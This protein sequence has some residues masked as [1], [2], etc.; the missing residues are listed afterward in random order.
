MNKT[1]NATEI[2]LKSILQEPATWEDEL[3]TYAKNHRVPIIEP[4]SMNFIASLIKLVQPTHILEIGTAIGYSALSMHHA[5]PSAKITTLERDEEMVVNATE[6]IANYSLNNQIDI[7]KGDALDSL[8]ELI[9]E[10]RTFDFIFI[11]AAKGQYKKFFEYAM[12]LQSDKGVILTDNVL[13]RGYVA[14]ELT[15]HKRF[16]KLGEKINDY[17]SWLMKNDNYHTSIIPIGDGIALS[18]K[19]L[20]NKEE[21]V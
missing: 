15:D 2:Y 16:Q 8:P 9:N 14:E 18:I 12:Q 1:L 5:L 17:N 19:N 20:K 3:M 7:I 4:V 10:N 13:F 11:D 21:H 6:N